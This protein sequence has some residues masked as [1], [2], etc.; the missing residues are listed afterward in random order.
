MQSHVRALVVRGPNGG[1]LARSLVRLLLRSDSLTPVIGRDPN[2]MPHTYTHGCSPTRAGC[3]PTRAGCS[4]T[5]AGCNPT[6]AGCN[7]TR[8]GC[9]PVCAG[10]RPVCAGCN[11]VCTGHLL[12][13]DLLLEAVLE[14]AARKP[15]R[16]GARARAPLPRPR[17]ARG[18]GAPRAPAQRVQGG[19]RRPRAPRR[20]AWVRRD[21]GR[22]SR[23]RRRRGVHLL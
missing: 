17:R 5:R 10:C 8:A 22:P 13:A 1:V 4:P 9:N 20:R 6:R 7:P 11:P 12:R 3:N 14:R 2:C 21:V 18:L 23:A 16:A 15:P 19:G